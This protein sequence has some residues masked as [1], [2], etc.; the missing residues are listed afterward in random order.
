MTTVRTW[1]G[2]RT[3]PTSTYSSAALHASCGQRAQRGGAAIASI[4]GRRHRSNEAEKTG[5][6]LQQNLEQEIDETLLFC[7]KHFVLKTELK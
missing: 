4:G 5:L 3:T 7:K 6:N 1:L 2:T